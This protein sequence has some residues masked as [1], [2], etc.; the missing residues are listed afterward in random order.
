MFGTL[1]TN[2]A[3]LGDWGSVADCFRQAMTS[4]H[5]TPYRPANH[6]S[7]SL[8]PARPRLFECQRHRMET[9]FGSLKDRRHIYFRGTLEFGLANPSLPV[10]VLVPVDKSLTEDTDR[11]PNNIVKIST[12]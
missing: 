3:I 6:Q 10:H 5:S 9:L 8:D 7:K 2:I 11:Q 1:P 12:L 4:R